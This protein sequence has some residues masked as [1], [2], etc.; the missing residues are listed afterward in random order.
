MEKYAALRVRGSIRTRVLVLLLGM[1]ITVAAIISY[2]S[3]LSLLET[4]REA[5]QTSS[6]TLRLQIEDYLRQ[7][8]TTNAQ[9]NDLILQSAQYDAESVAQYAARIFEKPEVFGSASYWRAEDHMFT[10]SEGQYINNPDEVSTV[11]V[12]NFVEIDAALRRDLQI[13]A[14]L[15]S[16]LPQTYESDP[17]TL[18]LYL[19]TKEG[20]T[21][22]YPNVGLGAI[23]PPDW[24]VTQRPWYVAA[25]EDNPQQE[26][27]W[28]SVYEDATGQGL[29][30]TAA[31][32][33]YT[34]QDEFV[35]VVGVDVTLRDISDS[36]KATRLLGGGYAFL[37][38]E[39]GHTIVLP[40]QGYWDI[41]GRAVES[42]EFGTDLAEAPEEFAPVLAK[43]VA[44]AAG[45]DSL[46]VNGKELFIAYAPVESTGWSLASV[47]EAGKVMGAVEGL[48]EKLE[49]S[50]QSLMLKRLLPLGVGL[51][52]L[53]AVI[54]IMLTNRLVTPLQELAMAAQQLGGGEWDIPLPSVGEDEI[55]VLT[56]A[57]ATMRTQLRELLEGLEQR[58]DERTRNLRAAAEVSQA[59][60]SILDPDQL[61]PQVVEL[62]RERFDLYYVGLF[63]LDEQEQFAVLRA[64]TGEAGRQM[65]SRGHQLEVGGNSMIGQC[66]ATDKA[67]IQLDVGEAA[68]RFDNPLLPET[69]SEMALPLRSRGKVIGAMTVQSTAAA[70]FDETDIAVLQA[71]ADQLANAIANAELYT[72]AQT[73]LAE[74]RATQRHYLVQAWAEYLQTTTAGRYETSGPDVAPLGETVLP[75]ARQAMAE[76]RTLVRGGNGETVEEGA[77][78][79]IPALVAPIMLRDQ[80]LGALGVRIAEGRQSWSE[81]EIT[82]VEAIAEQFALAADNLRLVEATQRR[83]AREQLVGEINANIRS[84]LEVEAVLERALTELGKALDADQAAAYLGTADEMSPAER[85]QK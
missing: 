81:E 29:L 82:L 55:G 59:I 4:G 62:V 12:P 77:G 64:G 78:E 71:M 18:A 20:I 69:R 48:Q 21:W 34:D 14:H 22:Y 61:L 80:P 68:V 24:D 49:T 23:L 85:G 26:T 19:A 70:A 40:Q 10:G 28:T 5:Q 50:T 65:L 60:T 58:M 32:P 16:I 13:S 84:Q 47:V 66:V 27:V 54:G 17:H 76:R 36:V 33:V 8:T 63:L 2:V 30:V 83:A 57:F 72:A 11:F 6:A 38:D 79:K 9:E 51:V 31:V 46:E 73:A 1:V 7:L 43:M 42:D 44:G 56:Q 37:V 15:D 3:V 35:G 74:A 41:L 45:F 52:V 53:M 67:D 39:T 25:V 75:E